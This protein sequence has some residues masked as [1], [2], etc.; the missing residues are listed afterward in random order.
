M[1]TTETHGYLTITDRAKDL[2]KSGGE[3]ISSLDLENTVIAHPLV[4]SCAVIAVAHPKWDE[5]PLLIVV[6]APEGK[7][8]VADLMALLETHFAKW[9]L[10][11]DVVFVDDLPMTA[12]G[13]IRKLNLRET[14]WDHLSA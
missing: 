9:Q 12:T 11:D 6:A 8:E 3:W 2:I 10:P 1:A 13:K 4:A 5:R 7:P 14:Y